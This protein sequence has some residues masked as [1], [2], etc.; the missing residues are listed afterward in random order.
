MMQTIDRIPP[1]AIEIEK[2]VLSSFFSSQAIFSKYGYTITP[3]YFYGPITQRIFKYMQENN[4]T[5]M[6]IISNQF[7][8][9]AVEIAEICEAY[10]PNLHLENEIKIL[11]DRYERRMMI[12]AAIQN[13]EAAYSDYDISAREIIER[14][15][16]ELNKT[17]TYETA[18]ENVGNVI[19]RLMNTFEK[20]MVDGQGLGLKTGISDVDA[21]IG[22]FVDSEMVMIAGRPSMGK[23]AFALQIAR[24]NALQGNPVLIFSIETSNEQ[25]TGRVLCSHAEIS[26]DAI[27]TGTLPKYEF[28]KLGAAAETV[29]SMPIYTDETPS[30]PIMQI[31]AKAE[32]YVKN[33]GVRLIIIDHI[34]LITGIEHGRSRNEELSKISKQIKA[35]GKSLKIPTITLCQ[36]SREVEKRQPPI[37]RLSDLYESGSLEQDTDKVIFLYREE[38]YKRDSDKKGI[39]EIILAKN[40]NGKTGYI[41]LLFDKPTMVFRNLAKDDEAEAWQDRV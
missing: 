3:D 26:F 20:I 22:G 2:S 18:P 17:N 36:L 15:I 40:K 35:L 28:P 39:A 9:H 30:I 27:L 38:Y 10:S 41:N 8:D 4:C 33:Y 29:K 32:N 37:P 24:Y 23:T 11:K 7:P 31:V 12:D 1:Q 5:D 25:I 21:L 6:M 13:S 34:G 14:T 19:P 16:S